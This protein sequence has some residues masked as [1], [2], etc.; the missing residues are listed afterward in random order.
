MKC[1]D[2]L[3]DWYWQD[4][5]MAATLIERGFKRTAHDIVQAAR[6]QDLPHA[7]HL[8]FDRVEDN[9][10]TYVEYDLSLRPPPYRPEEIEPLKRALK[11]SY[12]ADSTCP[13]PSGSNLPL[14]W[15]PGEWWA[16]GLEVGSGPVMAVKIA[17]VSGSSYQEALANASLIA[18]SKGMYS[19]LDEALDLLPRINDDDPMVPALVEWCRNAR[20]LMLSARGRK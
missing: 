12:G 8:D 6:E 1:G 4:G 19:L 9:L 14:P 13:C 20:A 15:T 5:R 16:S 17:K 18:A 7:C 3:F 11:Q 2:A 10:R